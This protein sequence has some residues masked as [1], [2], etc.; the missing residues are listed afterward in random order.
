[1]LDAVIKD[2]FEP[3]SGIGRVWRS[4][5]IIATKLQYATYKLHMHAW[6]IYLCYTISLHLFHKMVMRRK[7]TLNDMNINNR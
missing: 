7:A 1:M 6:Y 2:R 4:A 3:N 5:R